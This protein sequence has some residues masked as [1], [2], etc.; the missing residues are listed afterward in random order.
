MT[1]AEQIRGRYVTLRRSAELYSQI[2]NRPDIRMER[3]FDFLLDVFNQKASECVFTDICVFENET[4]EVKEYS[5]HKDGF[6]NF[7]KRVI[8]FHNEVVVKIFMDELRNYINEHDGY[9]AFKLPYQK[10]PHEPLTNFLQI[11]IK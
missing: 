7:D 10:Y 2:V 8:E 9:K 3:V 6:Y 1:K 5:I 11:S 4:L